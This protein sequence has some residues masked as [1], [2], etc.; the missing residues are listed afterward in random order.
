MAENRHIMEQLGEKLGVDRKVICKAL[1]LSELLEARAGIASLS[2]LRLTGSCRHVICLDL[3]AKT[4]GH[5]LNQ[6]DAV[7]LSSMNKKSYSEAVKVISSMLNLE[8]KMTLR[9]LA[10]QFGC[11]G[12]VSL[13]TDTLQRY[14]SDQCGDVDF[15]A[16]MFLCAAVLV[17]CRKLKQKIDVVKLKERSGAKKATLDR[18]TAQLGKYVDAPVGKTVRAT[19]HKRTLIDMVEADI[20]A[21]ERSQT[22]RLEEDGEDRKDARQQK[23]SEADYQEWKRRILARAAKTS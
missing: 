23:T 3:A 8:E 17:A 11:T 18:L 15:H 12:A 4:S 7:K 19:S 9:E 13:A 14:I 21:D 10:V 2:A 6:V 5:S 16:P 1:E 20:Q 22:Q